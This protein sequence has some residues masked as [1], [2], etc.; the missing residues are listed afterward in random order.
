MMVAGIYIQRKRGDD[1]NWRGE[2]GPV[3]ATAII[4]AFR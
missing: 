3:A 1:G 2:G 4:I